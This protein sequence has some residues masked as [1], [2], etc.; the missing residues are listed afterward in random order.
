MAKAVRP[1]FAGCRLGKTTRQVIKPDAS[2][3]LISCLMREAVMPQSPDVACKANCVETTIT[4]ANDFCDIT[5]HGPGDEFT[6]APDAH[7]STLGTFS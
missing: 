2:V 6:I 3:V 4:R 1:G 5:Y 7:A